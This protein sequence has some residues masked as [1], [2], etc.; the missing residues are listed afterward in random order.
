MKWWKSFGHAWHGIRYC[1]TTQ[2]NFRIHLVVLLI[3][4]LLGAIVKLSATEWLII[5]GFA[6]LVLTLEVVNTAIEYL[7]DTITRDIH[8]VIKTVKDISA[9]AVLIA[10]AGSVVS[11]AIIFF[12]KMLDLFR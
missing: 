7:C 6:A 5:T 9:A 1:F 11:G 2:L 12:P 4:I 10:V 8:P 3:V